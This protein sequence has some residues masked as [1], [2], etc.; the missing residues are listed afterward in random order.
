MSE[1]E[2]YVLVYLAGATGIWKGIP[3]GIA[4]NIHP[5]YIALFTALGS[6]TSVLVLYFAGNTFRTWVLKKVGTKRIERK[7][8]KFLRFSNKYGAFG[9]GLITTGLLGPF[10]SLFLGLLLVE[11]T[12]KFIVYLL[13]GI[14]LWS[15]IL[16]YF[17]YPLAQLL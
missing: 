6:I 12:R 13:V 10:T 15:F 2:K 3:A 11:E 9:L 14:F 8:N 7:K 16:A 17:F 4:L 1:P 5:A